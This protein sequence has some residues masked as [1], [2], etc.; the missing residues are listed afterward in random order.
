MYLDNSSSPTLN[1]VS[2]NG[3][4]ADVMGGGMASENNSS[5]VL[6]NVAFHGNHANAY[7]GGMALTNSSN[8]IL[9]NV[10]FSGN[11]APLYGGGM[12]V[13]SSNPI[14]S[15]VTFSGNHV[16]TSGGGILLYN[17]NLQVRNSILWGNTAGSGAQVENYLN[18]SAPVYTWVL[19]QGGGGTLDADPQFV[20][21]DGPDGVSG[22]PD[23]NLRLNFGS[24]AIDVGDNFAC[25][26]IDLDGLSRPGDGNADGTATCDLGAYEA[27]EMLCAA[28]YNFTK[29]SGVSIQVDTPGNLACLYVDEMGSDHAHATSGIQTGRYWL[30]RGLQNDK[31]SPASGFSLT[32]TLPVSMTPDSKDKV[33]RYTGSAQTWDCGLTDFD[34]GAKT[35]TRSG[36]TALSDW[37]VGNDV[38]TAVLL[39]SLD[40]RA[41]TSVPVVVI[42][43]VAMFGG[44]IGAAR[45]K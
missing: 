5:P 30:I 33:C 1:D 14:L 18:S 28:P 35:I 2:F 19:I 31:I 13:V 40:A 27:G 26:F 41:E 34:A 9:N 6:N 37:A 11:Q 43:L 10:I 36:I 17:S 29:Q 32:L 8:S 7:G 24:P 20:D 22:T 3:N 15:N 4:Q 12:I 38:A 45:R 42:L 23:D 16:D 25:P 39:V 21:A 44:A